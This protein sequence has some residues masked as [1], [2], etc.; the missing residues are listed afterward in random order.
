MTTVFCVAAVY[1]CVAWAAWLFLTR[2]LVNITRGD[3]VYCFVLAAIWPA[4]PGALIVLLL[5]GLRRPGR[6][7]ASQLPPILIG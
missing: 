1:V 2:P 6:T 7:R 4:I 3:R 5:R